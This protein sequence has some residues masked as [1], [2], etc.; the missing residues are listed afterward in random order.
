MYAYIRP[1]DWDEG[2]PPV[3]ASH[4]NYSIHTQP[5]SY[6]RPMFTQQRYNTTFP[7]LS[8][9]VQKPSILHFTQI[10]NPTFHGDRFLSK[11]IYY[12]LEVLKHYE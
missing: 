7:A 11:R 2:S 10:R 6:S 3:V 5:H 4:P 12:C 9:K 8:V 1:A